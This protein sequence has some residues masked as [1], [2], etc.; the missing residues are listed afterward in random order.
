[1]QNLSP[2]KYGQPGSR[3]EDGLLPAAAPNLP[4]S[5]CRFPLHSHSALGQRPDRARRL[6]MAAATHSSQLTLSLPL[7]PSFPR[8]PL[9]H[10]PAGPQALRLLTRI[11]S[12]YSYM[13]EALP[14]IMALAL[15][16]L[17]GDRT[18]DMRLQSCMLL[19]AIGDTF[20][21]SV[22]PLHFEPNH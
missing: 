1:M 12:A 11:H 21:V 22:A 8:A 16:C 14:E 15:E 17:Q 18:E 7:S 4:L 3:R 6:R 19:S 2:R 13:A 20:G 5:R 10:S 9:P